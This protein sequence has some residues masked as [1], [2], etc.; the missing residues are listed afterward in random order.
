MVLH[1]DAFVCFMW[2]LGMFRLD[3]LSW[4]R[5]LGEWVKTFN[6]GVT[7]VLIYFVHRHIAPV[8]I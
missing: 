4:I 8:Y 1:D 2:L 7:E 3:L 5:L 6:S